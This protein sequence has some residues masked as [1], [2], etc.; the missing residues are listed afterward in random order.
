MLRDLREALAAD[1]KAVSSF[2]AFAS[3][4]RTR[5]IWWITNAWWNETVPAKKAETRKRRFALVVSRARQ[6]GR[7]VTAAGTDWPVIW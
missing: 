2:K 5:Y 6:K 1:K 4:H 7:P 3:S